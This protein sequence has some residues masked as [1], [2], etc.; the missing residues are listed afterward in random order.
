MLFVG[1]TGLPICRGLDIRRRASAKQPSIMI[2]GVRPNE[3]FIPCL[4]V[5]V[6]PPPG[7]GPIAG[8]PSAPLAGGSGEAIDLTDD[9]TAPVAQPPAPAPLQP[10][11]MVSNAVVRAYIHRA[12][13]LAFL[14]VHVW[15]V[16]ATALAVDA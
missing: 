15:C 12:F 6:Q 9:T 7:A 3:A 2:V 10:E 8:Q 14:Y 13:V 16:H 1:Y 11:P 5:G 4:C